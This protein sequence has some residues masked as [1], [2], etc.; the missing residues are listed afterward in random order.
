MTRCD[1]GEAGRPPVSSSPIGSR[2]HSHQ[3]RLTSANSACGTRRGRTGTKRAQ[4]D[5]DAA[6]RYCGRERLP[7][8]PAPWQRLAGAGYRGRR[9]YGMA[10]GPPWRNASE[11]RSVPACRTGWC[12]RITSP[13][14]FVFGFPAR[15]R[16]PLRRRQLVETRDPVA[17]FAHES[18]ITSSTRADGVLQRG[19]RERYGRLLLRDSRPLTG[20]TKRA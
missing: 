6:S 18:G 8:G 2:L 14:S 7:G 16:P 5:R 4:G 12:S 19:G 3:A 10:W 11:K 9:R 20:L 13:A 17:A 15:A 1:V